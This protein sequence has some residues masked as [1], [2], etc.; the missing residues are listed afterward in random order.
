PYNVDEQAASTMKDQMAQL[1][2]FQADVRTVRTEP[3]ATRMTRARELV[4]GDSTPPLLP[5]VVLPMLLLLRSSV[6]SSDDL[7]IVIEFIDKLP[8]EL[9]TLVPVREQ[10]AFARA[11]CGKH[12]EAISELDK[13]IQ[14][15][16][17]TPERLGLLG[18]RFKRLYESATTP[19]E[20]LMYLNK[21]IES[22]EQ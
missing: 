7:K 3:P 15:F 17:P 14:Q 9:M 1:A 8:D 5:A 22:Y 10:L 6:Y 12:L 18:G 16:G 21:C 11:H 13:L 19:Q 2:R 20:Q 4:A